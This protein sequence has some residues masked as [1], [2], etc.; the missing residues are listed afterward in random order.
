MRREPELNQEGWDWRQAVIATAVSLALTACGASRTAEADHDSYAQQMADIAKTLNAGE[1]YQDVLVALDTTVPVAPQMVG[2]DGAIGVS[3]PV[4]LADR[5]VYGYFKRDN[6][7]NFVGGYVETDSELLHP[8]DPARG[9]SAP[10]F[11][12]VDL[13]KVCRPPVEGEARPYCVVAANA[14]SGAGLDATTE[15][16]GDL[17]YSGK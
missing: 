16:I 9:P 8:Y 11:E 13:S 7:G 10:E 15:R 14:E 3:Q 17:A 6:A 12:V 2:E 1:T 4:W 5:G